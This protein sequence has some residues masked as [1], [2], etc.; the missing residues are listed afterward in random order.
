MELH[1]FYYNYYNKL[2]RKIFNL[3]MV[4]YLYLIYNSGS[5]KYI[6]YYELV[7]SIKYIKQIINYKFIVFISN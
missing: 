3:V 2:V 6:I 5:I 4:I 7:K 1:F